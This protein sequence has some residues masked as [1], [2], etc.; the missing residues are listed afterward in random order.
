VY[1]LVGTLP[2]RSTLDTR[3]LL[4]SEINVLA[5][6]NKGGR[7]DIYANKGTCCEESLD[8]RRGGNTDDGS[9]FPLKGLD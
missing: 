3:Y 7:T 9:I 6:F 8:R 1:A 4:F 2:P 5:E